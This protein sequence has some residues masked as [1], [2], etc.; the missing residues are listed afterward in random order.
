MTIMVLEKWFQTSN[1]QTRTFKY[2][3]INYA[4]KKDFKK[5][6]FREFLRK[7]LG[8]SFLVLKCLCKQK[9]K[10]ECAGGENGGQ[11]IFFYGECS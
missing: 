11:I 10:T 2:Q 4:M 9:N 7:M 6:I 8:T 3:P 1:Q 5:N